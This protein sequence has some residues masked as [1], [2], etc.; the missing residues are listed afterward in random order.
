MKGIWQKLRTHKVLKKHSTGR[1]GTFPESSF[2]KGQDMLDLV[3]H[4]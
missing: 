4:T 1:S 3:P 2:A